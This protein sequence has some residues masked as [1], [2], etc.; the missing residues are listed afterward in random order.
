MADIFN[1]DF[2]ANNPTDDVL[3]AMEI[4][5]TARPAERKAY[6]EGLNMNDRFA[7]QLKVV[8]EVYQQKLEA[9]KVK[10]A[11]GDTAQA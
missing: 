9:E 4:L 3:T 10:L 6:M 5:K 11:G 1:N 7:Q 8:D 2:D